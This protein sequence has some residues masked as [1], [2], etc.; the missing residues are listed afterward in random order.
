MVE[1]DGRAGWEDEAWLRG[2]LRPC[3]D[4]WQQRHSGIPEAAVG[5]DLGVVP[6][7][8][9]GIEAGVVAVA[10]LLQQEGEG[11]TI[12]TSARCSTINDDV[13]RIGKEFLLLR[14]RTNY[15][16]IAPFRLS[17]LTQKLR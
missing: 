5:E 3:A 7:E 14:L 13:C 11:L 9:D 4:L 6:P 10:A 17:F 12:L 16:G 1:G 15:H 2:F 8:D